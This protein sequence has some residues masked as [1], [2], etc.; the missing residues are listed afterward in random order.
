MAINKHWELQ[1]NW[2]SYADFKEGSVEYERQRQENS[3]VGW[4]YIGFD[5]QDNRIA[6]IG[7]TTNS[8]GTR[9]Y[10]SGNTRYALLCAFKIQE[11]F[12]SDTVKR[13]EDAVKD[14]L[15][16]RY[17]RMK[18]VNSGEWSEWFVVTPSEMR[19]VVH[20][21]L[22]EEFSTYMH[23]YFCPDRDVG[24]IYTWEN[25]HLLGKGAASPYQAVDTSNP[26]PAFE[27]S[28]PPGCGAECDC[29]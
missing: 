8:L 25:T 23:C 1:F 9:A 18:F 5:T 24:V 21:F 4:I 19:A 10:S 12:N 29:W 7:K 14:F 17:E 20:D 3:T 11:G 28:M 26:P 16:R 27:C 6:K 13:I 2:D 22:Y 15:W